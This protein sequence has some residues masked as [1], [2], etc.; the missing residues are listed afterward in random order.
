MVSMTDLNRLKG[1]PLSGV[2]FVQDYVEFHFDGKILRALTRASVTSTSGTFTFPNQGSRDAFCLLIGHAVEHVDVR[3]EER[4]E[5][6][7]DDQ[8]VLRVPLASA[9][10]TGPEAAHFVPGENLPIDVW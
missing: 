1:E 9:E 6:V 2:A 3:E 5:V 4:I 8:S 7:F 10:R